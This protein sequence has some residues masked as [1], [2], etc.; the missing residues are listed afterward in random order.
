MASLERA[1]QSCFQEPVIIK[2][3]QALDE[4]LVI[5]I[6]EQ[7]EEILILKAQAIVEKF[8]ADLSALH[9]GLTST[10]A[11]RLHIEGELAKLRDVV[12]QEIERRVDEDLT[13]TVCDLLEHLSDHLHAETRT[14]VESTLAGD[15]TSASNITSPDAEQLRA[16]IA[17]AA[18]LRAAQRYFEPGHDVEDWLAAEKALNLR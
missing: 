9:P 6:D 10:E 14:P 18:Y 5:G 16:K 2:A 7:P 12:D 3:R 8:K 13:D 15:A 1:A 17:E 4:I 11:Y